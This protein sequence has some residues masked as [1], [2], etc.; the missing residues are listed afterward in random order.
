MSHKH[1]CHA[2][3]CERHCKPEYLMCGYHWRQV[4][5][6]VQSLVYRFYQDGQCNLD[7]LPSEEWHAA[8]DLA[9]ACVA[10]KESRITEEA[11]T[12]A[13]DKM[14]ELLEKEGQ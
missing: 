3:G 5:R 6:R 8:A 2:R 12:K 11:W 9:I 14:K 1:T 13:S 4:P 7:P 10:F